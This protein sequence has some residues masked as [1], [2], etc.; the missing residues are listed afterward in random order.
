MAIW[1]RKPEERA[2]AQPDHASQ[3]GSD[4]WKLLCVAN[5]LKPN[6]SRGGN[7][8]DNTVDESFA[9]SLKKDRIRK[10]IYKILDLARAD[11]FACIEVF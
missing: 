10:R 3:H 4:D 2:I 11:V 6:M 1:R 7:C 9:S 5:N 8:W